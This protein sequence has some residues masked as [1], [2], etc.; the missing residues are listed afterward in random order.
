MVESKNL[1]GDETYLDA[2]DKPKVA[3]YAFVVCS[4]LATKVVDVCYVICIKW[5]FSAIKENIEIKK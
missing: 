1:Y 5:Y 2:F 4:I 3:I